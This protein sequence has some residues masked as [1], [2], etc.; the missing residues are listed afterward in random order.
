M[1]FYSKLGFYK[2]NEAPSIKVYGNQNKFI[3]GQL[4]FN[5]AEQKGERSPSFNSSDLSFILN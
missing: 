4:F 5:D 1:K 3:T 2:S